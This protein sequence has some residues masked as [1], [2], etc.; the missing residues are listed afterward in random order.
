LHLV[1]PI[2]SKIRQRQGSNSAVL[3]PT[4]AL[5]LIESHLDGNGSQP[6]TLAELRATIA[7]A[8]KL[9][10]DRCA[11]LPLF[12]EMMAEDTGLKAKNRSRCGKTAS[13]SA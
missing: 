11:F 9:S 2:S 6:P 3:S 12:L 8:K 4:E 10:H 7:M 1:R 13:C 5:S